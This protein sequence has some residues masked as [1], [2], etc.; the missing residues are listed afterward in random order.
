MTPE[1][2]EWIDRWCSEWEES[3]ARFTPGSSEWY[4]ALPLSVA[5]GFVR[6]MEDN[7]LPLKEDK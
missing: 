4:A 2:W 5:I 1:R 7:L 3:I 6:E